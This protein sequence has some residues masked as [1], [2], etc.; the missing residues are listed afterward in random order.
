MLRFLEA[1]PDCF[2]VCDE[3]RC[4]NGHYHDLLS[5]IA[6]RVTVAHPGRLRL[7]FRSKGSPTW[8][9]ATPRY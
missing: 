4:G 5:P 6:A 3:A 1:L 9:T 7:I 8:R 2:E